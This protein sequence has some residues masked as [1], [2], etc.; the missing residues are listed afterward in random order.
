MNVI[1]QVGILT[2]LTSSKIEYVYTLKHVDAFKSIK[3]L[4]TQEPLLIGLLTR[5]LKSTY[6]VMQPQAVVYWQGF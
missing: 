1:E 3:R 2:P 5:Q 6:G 4:L